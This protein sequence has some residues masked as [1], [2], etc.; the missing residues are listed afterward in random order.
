MTR[1]LLACVDALIP[2][3]IAALVLAFPQWFTKKN[4]RAEENQGLAKRL[5]K[6]GWL[7]LAAGF[8]ILFANIANSLRR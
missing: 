5:R 1:L 6:A 3:G 8:L 4:L 2:L 7:L